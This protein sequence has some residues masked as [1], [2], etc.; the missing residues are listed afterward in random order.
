MQVLQ[1]DYTHWQ[2]GVLAT[3]ISDKVIK[4]AQSGIY[5]LEKL[6][7]VSDAYKKM[8]FDKINEN[9]YSI[10][11]NVK[12]EIIFRRF[13]LMNEIYPFNKKF[14]IIFCRNVM[15]YF[16]VETRNELITK[17]YKHTAKNGYLII[18]HSENLT[19]ELCQY[20]NILPSI[21]KKVED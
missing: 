5:T 2:A 14:D 13:N 4:Q 8:F 16:N 18:G 21:Y 19:K 3:D 11:E 15:I 7:N 10:K 20:K 12:K 1:N 17:F 9:S 6:D